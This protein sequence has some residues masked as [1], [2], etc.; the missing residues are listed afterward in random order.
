MKTYVYYDSGTTNSRAYLVRNGVVI[1]TLSEK[2]GTVDN[3]LSGDKRTLEKALFHMYHQL[4]DANH[5]TDAEID[6]IYMSGMATSKNGIYEVDYARLPLGISDY[7]KTAAFQKSEIFG[8]TIGYFTGAVIMPDD[9]GT[10]DNISLFNNVRGEEI[11]LFGIMEREKDL[12]CGQKTAVIMPGSHT[13]VLFTDDRKITK[14][15]SCMGGELF[16]AVSQHTI[17]NASVSENPEHGDEKMLYALCKGYEAVKQYG[18]NRAVYMVRT[19]DL[20]SGASQGERDF[21][22]EGVINAGIMTGIQGCGE[23]PSLDRICIAGK[24]VYF[25]IFHTL[26]KHDHWNI[27]CSHLEARAESF[28]LRGFLEIM[29]LF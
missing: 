28:A 9:G 15:L 19:L 10:V 27:P 3:V 8:R 26:M 4:L 17:L 25:D 11:E 5:I 6:M 16:A 24:Q 12:F 23:Y 14:I 1:D 29:K 2:T 20:F 22:Y 21:F 13:H 18:F 7:K